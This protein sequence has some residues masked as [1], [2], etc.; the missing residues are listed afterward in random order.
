M[1]PDLVAVESNAD[2]TAYGSAF[3][4]VTESQ[5]HLH[6]QKELIRTLDFK[7]TNLCLS[8]VSQRTHLVYVYTDQICS[9]L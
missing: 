5:I 4:I 7:C 3:N 6:F 9:I 8:P 1:Y 2:A